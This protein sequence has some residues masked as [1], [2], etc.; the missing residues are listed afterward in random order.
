M[1]YR[2]ICLLL[3]LLITGEICLAQM[4][5]QTFQPTFASLEQVDPVPEWFKDAKFGIYFHWGVYSVPAFANEWYPR[6]MYIKGSPEN[7]HHMEIYGD[8]SQWPYNLFITGAEDK[9][10]NFIQFAPKRK[11]EGGQFDPDEWAQLFADAG[12]KF[13]GPVAE[14]H[15]GFSMWAS[16][17]N[18]WNAKDTGPK[19]DLVGL[20][21][22]AIR[23]KNMRVILSMHHAYNITGYYEP[24]PETND[25]KLGMLYGQQGKVKN[26]AFWLKKHKEIIDN[27]QPD[28]IW[29][30]FNL[31]VI[32]KPVLLE[33]LSYYYNKAAEWD[34]QVVAT[35]KDGLNTRC[36]VLDYE[37]GG[38]IDITENYWLTDDAISSSSWCYTEGIGYYSK[39][40]I[41]HGFFD[42]ISKNGNLLLNISPK[43]DGSIPQEQKEVLLAMGAWLK[44]YGEA[45]YATRAWEKYG[46]GPTKMGAAHGVF[47]APAEG[48]AKDVRYTHSKDNTTL[49]TI[50]LGWEQGQ[51]EIILKSLSSGRIDIKNLKSVALIND[52][53]GKYLPL[54]YKQ[55]EEGLIV[56]LPERSFD[57]LAYVLKLNFDGKIPPL[58]KY[59]DL[60]CTPHYYLIPGDNTGSLVLGSDLRLTGKRKIMANQWKFEHTGKGFYKILNRQNSKKTFE[61]IFSGHDLIL[62]DFSGKDNQFW[63][64]EEA[65]N[66][67]FKISN[68]QF[69]EAVLS[70]N[71]VIAEGNKAGLRNAEDDSSFEWKLIEVC[72]IKQEP[73]KPHT[74]P[75]TIEAEDFD[76]GCSGD[77]FHDLD[78]RNEGRQYRLSEGVDIEKCAAGGYNMGWTR[79][80]EW[81]AYTVT[82]RKSASYRISFYIAS[83]ND[84]GKFH[85]EC[86]GEDKTGIISI[87][88]TAGFQNWEII[89][90]TIKLDTGQH[91]LR[92]FV[93]GDYFNLDKMVFEEI[94]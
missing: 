39:K 70:V 64:I 41:L 63:K 33:F 87:P 76:S 25:K 23:K 48:T 27:Y 9:Q 93:D 18:P 84:S 52:K 91:V 19:L 81:T 60:D 55:T 74:I 16:S 21:T 80:G 66:A 11:S 7:K 53:A 26:E 50:L 35:Y 32:S 86:D 75:G 45:V 28:I 20:L 14:H 10:G 38:P 37:R 72:E 24:V 85:L 13:A 44:K 58:D 92:L 67:S 5:K 22:E 4:Q 79:R 71:T 78:D 54:T 31:H 36:A 69:P 2:Y 12:A 47:M 83:A 61:C 49:Y 1:K 68:K 8:V 17:V 34:K 88:N 42:R 6:N 90:K 62:S 40:Q 89:K 3:A 30:D 15:D 57:E 43:A 77:A 65:R 59:A 51:N 56:D 73:F 82:V 46:E 29:Q 94:K